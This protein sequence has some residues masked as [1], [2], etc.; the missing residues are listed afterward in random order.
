MP[1]SAENSADAMADG[2]AGQPGVGFSGID[3]S[4]RLIA[5]RRCI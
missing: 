5:E 3:D 4:A 2:R 1:V